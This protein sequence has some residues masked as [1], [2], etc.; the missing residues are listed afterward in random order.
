M[1]ADRYDEGSAGIARRRGGAEE[2]MSTTTSP[3]E[4]EKTLERRLSNK[5]KAI[6]LWSTVKH[7]LVE[8]SALPEYLQDNSFILRYYRADWRFKHAL[9]SMFSMHNETFNIWS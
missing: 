5:E 9:Y 6:E 8:Y 7:Q 1:G 4:K 3:R 2:E